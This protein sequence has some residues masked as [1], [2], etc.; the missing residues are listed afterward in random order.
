MAENSI[1]EIDPAADQAKL[2]ALLQC[3]PLLE[4]DE[5]AIM[6]LILEKAAL[7]QCKKDRTIQFTVEEFDAKLREIEIRGANDSLGGWRDG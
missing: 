1:P 6:E 3:L 7:G 5:R 2:D 4:P